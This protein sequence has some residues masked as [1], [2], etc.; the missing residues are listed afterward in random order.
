MAK[1]IFSL[2]GEGR[3]HATRTRT[4]VEAL[5]REHR[6]IV[7]APGAAYQL[8][9]DAYFHSDRVA[10]CEIPGLQ[11]RYRGERLDYLKSCCLALPFLW[12]MRDWTAKIE[13]L[14]RK[15]R[16][17]LAITDFEPLL[18]RAAARCGVPYVSFDHQHFLLV[19]D[20]SGLPW[21]LRWKARL[22]APS[23]GMFYRGQRRTIVSSF[24]Q[25]PLKPHMRH[26]TQIGTL[27]RP[28]ILRSRPVAGQHVLVYM[29]RFLRKNLLD[30]LLHCGRPVKVYG[31][32]VRPPLDGVVFCEVDERNFLHDLSQCF[33]V[34][35]N[36]G[37]QLVGEA[38]YLKKPFLAL[39]ESG[40]FEQSINAHFVRESGAGDWIPFDRLDAEALLRFLDR[41]PEYRQQIR[42]EAVVGNAAAVDA[43]L[44]ELAAVQQTTARAPAYQAA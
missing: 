16:P 32:G 30:A 12:R 15:E 1:L 27:L 4:I 42:S 19:N 10:V 17:D 13:A 28:E 18:P 36:A 43:I 38:I 3:G 44:A 31:L 2:A 35:S 7:L 21:H 11:F 5:Q 33:A 9:A 34:V 40:N 8:L 25:P 24:Y 20:L 6:I 41:V 22:L 26:V 39:P 23:V 37:N 14:L 29:R